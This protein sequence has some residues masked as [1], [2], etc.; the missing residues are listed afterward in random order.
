MQVRHL[1][2][3][4]C[5]IDARTALAQRHTSTPNEWTWRF[6]TRVPE[7]PQIA[8]RI[9]ACDPDAQRNLGRRASSAARQALV[10]LV[11]AAGQGLGAD[12]S[13]PGDEGHRQGDPRARLRAH[14]VVLK[15]ADHLGLHRIRTMLLREDIEIR[16]S[17]LVLRVVATQLSLEPPGS[18]PRRVHQAQQRMGRLTPRRAPAR[19]RRRPRSSRSRTSGDPADPAARLRRL[20]REGSAAPREGARLPRISRRGVDAVRDARCAPARACSPLQ[21]CLKGADG[22]RIEGAHAAPADGANLMLPIKA[23]RESPSIDFRR[24]CTP[25]HVTRNQARP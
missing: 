7:P 13:A 21:Q 3:R 18:E 22:N 17:T 1:V 14:V 11:P 16:V 12:T 15:Y 5:A 19:S 6:A 9:I 2:S 24:P 23:Q 8:P 10:E 20:R 4:T 25:T